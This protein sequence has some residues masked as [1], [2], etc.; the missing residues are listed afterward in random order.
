MHQ[1]GETVLRM[2]GITK[3]FPGILANDN[4]SLELRAGEVLGLLG[5]NGAGKTTIMNILY[6]LHKPD[7]GEI[8]VSGRKVEITSPRQAVDLGIGMVH[9]QFMLVDQLTALENAILGMPTARPPLIDL[10]S[11]RVRF[12][13]LAK[14]YQILIDPSTPVW[15]LPV[16]D[17]QWLEIL[18]QLFRDAKILIL[19][20]PTAVLA[21]SQAQ[22]LFKKIRQLTEEGGSVI[23]ISHKLDEV[24]EITDRIT[25]LRDGHAIGTIMTEDATPSNLAQMMV[26]R[27]VYSDRKQRP[28]LETKQEMLV[29][30]DLCCNDDRGIPALK[31]LN[32][33][34]Y[35]GEIVGV[36][37]VSGNGQKELAENIAGLRQKVKGTIRI[38][39]KPV[40]GVIRDT[41]LLGYIPED[42]HKTGLVANFSVEENMILKIFDTHPFTRWGLLQGDAVRRTAG[43]LI[44]EYDIKTP[45]S[46]I[47]VRHL[48]G[49]NQQ[50]VVIAREIN[51]KPVLLV[52]SQPTRG[53][54]LGAVESVHDILLRER[55]RGT[56][57]LFIS[58]ELQE[59]MTLSDRIIVMFEG[60][61]MG[62]LDAENANVNLIGGMML[63]H[64]EEHKDRARI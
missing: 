51:G 43:A 13:K 14:E 30:E 59:V 37:G 11:V 64:R 41:S 6:G 5:E 55:S 3:Q 23:F 1:T 31:N 57:V 16:G 21:P 62:E 38:N 50:K 19:D 45:D 63:G 35:A 15:Q 24:L 40:T 52:A 53:L 29:I 10:E 7:K 22:Q 17:K 61:I 28:P 54:D 8:Y 25:V 33:T 42:K 56:A 48:S 12:E 36:A 49:G 60:E 20:E 58:A 39:D 34:V 4:V 26:G 27:P 46:T 44:E 9:Q 32:L 2:T 47:P 18:K